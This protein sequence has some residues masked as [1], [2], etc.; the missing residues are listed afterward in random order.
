MLLRNLESSYLSFLLLVVVT[1]ASPAA[2]SQSNWVRQGQTGL[3]YHMDIRGDRVL[4]YSTAGYRGGASLPVFS[5]V[6]EPNRVVNV[7]AVAGDNRAQIQAAIDQV[8]AMPLNAQ[9]FRGV[10]QLGAGQY[11]ISD[12]IQIGSGGVILRGVGDGAS[13]TSNTVLRSTSTQQIDM[14]QVGN[15]TQYANNL[16]RVGTPSAIV[17]KVVPGG[18][19]SF[20]VADPAAFNVGDWVN[21][22]REPT[23]DWFDQVSV[24]FPN[25]PSG[26]NWGWNTSDIRYT[27]Q[28]EREITRIE[29]DRVFVHAPLSHNID[30]RVA[31]GTIEHYNHR[32]IS[33]V[34][35]EGIRGTTVFDPSQTANV[36]GSNQ[37]TDEDHAWTFINLLHA[38]D[39]WVRDITGEHLALSTVKVTGVSRSVTVEDAKSVTPVS[40][41]T[42]GRRYA[43]MLNGGQFVLMK[44]LE[45]EFGRRDFA[46][47]STFNGFNRGPNVFLDATATDS[48]ATTGPHAGYATGTLYDN[49]SDDKGLEA[50]LTNNPPV[51][52]WRG[53]HTVFWNSVGPEFAI[54]NPPGSRN[55]LIGA[56]GGTLNLPAADGTIDSIGS[57]IDLN[58]AEN[59]LDSL[60]VQQLLEKQRN[61][62]LEKREY[63]L[64]DFDELEADG[65]GSADDVYVDPD[66]LVEVDNIPGYRNPYPIIGFDNDMHDALVPFS[67]TYDL[68]PDEEVV[69]AVLTMGTKRKGTHSDNDNIHLESLS[70]EIILGTREAWG[71]EFDDGLQVVTLELVGD[72]S[73]LQDGLLN[74]LVSDDRPVD[75]AHLQINVLPIV[76]TSLVG[77]Y[78]GDGFVSQSDLDLVLLNWGDAVVPAGFNEGNLDGG[79]PF[80]GLM[81]QNELDGV[82]LNWGSGTQPNAAAI[83]EPTGAALLS[84]G[85]LMA[86]RRQR[87]GGLVITR[88][89]AQSK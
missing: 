73:F 23:Q 46:N 29:G 68:A 86:L 24:D 55:Y 70:N 16:F 20:R 5:S 65:P 2:Y 45:S 34:G 31:N 14:I 40:I 4:D 78:N 13:A 26:N 52:G 75:W 71:T 15:F 30:G 85:G 3:V 72:V 89:P 44:D 38:Q 57:R 7:A 32:R 50:K 54:K 84:L 27:F 61:P 43:F 37:F 62:E 74:V 9:G 53:A 82:L 1:A 64:G 21:V 77:D 17:D 81:S 10:V 79:G 8:S 63:W 12:T 67:F 18:A 28:Q 25:D 69:S 76:A 51:H 6:V 83:P 66:W 59:P 56:T 80:D 41:V 36:G 33:N 49:V 47:N 19:T 87:P 35:I 58:D 60:Y 88:H 39:A 11:D 42:G 48:F 22:K